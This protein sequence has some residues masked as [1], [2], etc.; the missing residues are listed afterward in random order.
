MCVF[1][2]STFKMLKVPVSK[3][4]SYFFEYFERGSQPLSIL[5]GGGHLTK[6]HKGF[7]PRPK[8]SKIVSPNQKPKRLPVLAKILKG[9]Q[10]RP[11]YSKVASPDQNTQRLDLVQNTQRNT[12]G[13]STPVLWAFWAST[14]QKHTLSALY[15]SKMQKT[16]EK[17]TENDPEIRLDTQRMETG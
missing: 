15:R 2:E 12:T 10:P 4:Q 6:I 8:C 16:S 1:G 9:S 3:F 13:I 7:Q 11:K 5:V 14:P 17:S